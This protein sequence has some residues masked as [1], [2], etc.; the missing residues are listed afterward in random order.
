M[1]LAVARLAAPTQVVAVVCLPVMVVK[2]P[3]VAR[4]AARTLAVVMVLVMVRVIQA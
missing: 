4:L 2:V 1:V 3:V